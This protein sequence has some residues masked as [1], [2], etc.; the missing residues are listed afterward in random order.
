MANGYLFVH[1]T[2]ETECGEQIYFSVSCDGLHWKDLQGGNPV[3][4]SGI[5]EKGVRDPFIIKSKIDGKYIIIATD[6]RMANGRDWEEV[7]TD[8]SRCIVIWE[9]ENLIH[10]KKERMVE[11]GIPEAG[12]VWA[13][14]AVYCEEEDSYLVFWASRVKEN[15][16]EEP[17][18]RIYASLTKD[19]YSFT[20][21]IKYIEKENH[22]IDTTI[23]Q[24]GEFYYR[25]SK[26]ETTKNIV[27]DRGKDLLHGLFEPVKCEVLDNL[28]GVEG[29]EV[30]PLAQKGRW[31]LIVD[32][33][34]TGKGYMPILCDDL[35]NGAFFLLEEDAYDMGKS[36]KRHGSVLCI[37]EEEMNVLIQ[38]YGTED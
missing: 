22:I 33:F 27:V 15:N 9:S 13:P 16:E 25:F 21:P 38:A 11:V 3:L 7:Q 35:E 30:Y 36:K 6:L 32:R 10:W 31:C 29:P 34:A 17:K 1:F 26:D 19:F 37:T 24:A 23:V 18:H 12:C 20:E 2:G 14:E 8:G 5:G 4:M 28:L